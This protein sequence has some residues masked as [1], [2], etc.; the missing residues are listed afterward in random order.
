MGLDWLPWILLEG[1]VC[2]STL[3]WSCEFYVGF[4]C[5]I[6]MFFVGSIIGWLA[7]SVGWL[8]CYLGGGLEGYLGLFF[9]YV[10]WFIWLSFGFI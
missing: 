9:N 4:V 6:C 7:C 3:D 1:F 5:E 2:G 8:F 10:G